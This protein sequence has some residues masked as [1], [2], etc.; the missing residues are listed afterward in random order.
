MFHPVHSLFIF[1]TDN[2][3]I[4]ISLFIRV[5]IVNLCLLR[6]FSIKKSRGKLA[7][8]AAFDLFEI[9]WHIFLI[10]LRRLQIIVNRLTVSTRHRCHIKCGLHTSLNL[11][12]VNSCFQKI[13]NMLNHTQIF[14][15]ENIGS[16][17]ILIYREILTRTLL[18]N[19]RIFPPARM[20]TC[21]AVGI[22]SCKIIGQQTSSRIGNTHSA[23]YKCLYL[24]IIGNVFP[25][26]PDLPQGKFSCR[27]HTGSTEFLPELKCSVIGV[28]CLCT[29]MAVNIR[30]YFS[31]DRKDC[32]I[33]NDQ[34]IWP[35]RL[36]ILQF[37][38]IFPHTVKII[39]MCQNICRHI[40]FNSPCMCKC[41]S[42]CHLFLGKIFGFGSESE[43]LS[44]DVDRIGSI[45]NCNF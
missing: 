24:Q 2:S 14:G 23:M 36:H 31:G 20:C 41:N 15:I 35:V 30:A 11:K 43:C 27:Y 28:V 5:V 44:P 17:L 13:R 42:L 9:P 25:D 26:L 38:K 32:R 37:R 10:F 8:C 4:G 3:Q 6:R 40:N 12:T 19:H 16:A 21:P 34:C 45:N 22:P 33:C 39:I 7:V 18:F 1:R 29:D